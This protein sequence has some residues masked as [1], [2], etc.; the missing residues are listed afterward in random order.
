MERITKQNHR[1]RLKLAAV[2]LM[3]LATGCSNQS[4]LNI[5]GLGEDRCYGSFNRLSIAAA[6]NLNTGFASKIRPSAR[7]NRPLRIFFDSEDFDEGM[8]S[9][10][11]FALKKTIKRNIALLS[12]KDLSAVQRE[13]Q[14]KR[15]GKVDQGAL[16]LVAKIAGSDYL[17]TSSVAVNNFDQRLTVSFRLVDLETSGL[18]WTWLGC[19]ENKVT[20]KL[21]RAAAKKKKIPQGPK[22]YFS[23]SGG[24]AF[25]SEI[26][27]ETKINEDD[28]EDER[29][30]RIDGFIIRP[31]EDI[32]IPFD[33]GYYVAGTLGWAD[34]I[35]LFR[36]ELEGS[37]SEIRGKE[38][39]ANIMRD[40]PAD[41]MRRPR[42]QRLTPGTNDINTK[43]NSGSVSL[44]AYVNFNLND[45]V[46]PYLGLGLGGKFWELSSSELNFSR[47]AF[48]FPLMFGLDF[49]LT[50]GVFFSTEYRFEINS[51][52]SDANIE[53]FLLFNHN[54]LGKIRVEY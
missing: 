2:L 27:I 5:F 17:L 52:A 14:L 37:Y 26:K 28:V 34:P 36:I 35:G 41:T 46:Q 39:R 25:S 1:A 40:N 15:Q 47:G 31:G 11:V 22:A 54:L 44:N 29:A 38:I 33:A 19:I 10:L 7:A 42:A 3:F 23:L 8:T 20:D 50:E 30:G 51:S 43:L 6:Q 24:S 45:P 18:A 16:G 12:R 4:A 53:G 21:V 32:T 9:Q 48:L 13:R 49:H